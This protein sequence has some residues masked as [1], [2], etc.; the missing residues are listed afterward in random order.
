MRVIDVLLTI[1]EVASNDSAGVFLGVSVGFFIGK[2]R[3]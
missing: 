2:I 3:C 1:P